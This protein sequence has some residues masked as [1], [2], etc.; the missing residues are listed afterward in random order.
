MKKQKFSNSLS[1]TR[2]HFWKD[3]LEELKDLTAN[4][5]LQKQ[6]H[7]EDQANSSPSK[8]DSTVL[9]PALASPNSRHPIT[10]LHLLKDNETL[11]GSSEDHL[12]RC[13]NTKTQQCTRVFR[14]HSD[15]VLCLKVLEPLAS[16]SHL[17][18][19]PFQSTSKLLSSKLGTSKWIANIP[20]LF[21]GSWDKTI[22][23]W[24][25]QVSK[26]INFLTY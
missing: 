1:I 20:L 3:E 6:V 16:S 12:I 22:R 19:S 21:S 4:P 25:A 11:F 15:G 23:I 5:S 9:T 14:G 8:R 2:D 24:N 13:W 26:L 18:K 17:S 7:F 10:A